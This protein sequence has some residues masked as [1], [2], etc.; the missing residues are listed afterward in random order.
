MT[1]C[2]KCYSIDEKIVAGISASAAKRGITESEVAQSI[3]HSGLA[4]DTELTMAERFHF[5]RESINK[6]LDNL[7]IMFSVRLEGGL[8]DKF[9]VLTTLCSQMSRQKT[10][11]SRYA[12]VEQSIF[13]VLNDVKEMDIDLYEEWTSELNKHGRMRERYFYL[14]PKS[15]KKGITEKSSHATIRKHNSNSN[16]TTNNKEESVTE[17]NEVE[18]AMNEDIPDDQYLARKRQQADSGMKR[19]SHGH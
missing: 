7:L 15:P 13:E 6:S 18:K 3:L 5:K 2:R 17:L 14:Y 8:S 4:K 11:K 1:K 9:Q 19:F 10:R 12:V 16:V